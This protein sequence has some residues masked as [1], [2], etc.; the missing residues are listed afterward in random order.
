MKRK[1][2]IIPTVQDVREFVHY[3]NECECDLALEV[4]RHRVNAKSIMGIFSLDLSSPMTLEVSDD[5]EAEDF[6]RAISKFIQ[7]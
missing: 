7:Q 1:T 5:S 6:F 2:V 3:A 4:G